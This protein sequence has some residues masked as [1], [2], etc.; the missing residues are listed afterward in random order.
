MAT[1]RC[2]TL[3]FTPFAAA[4]CLAQP[5]RPK[6]IKGTV[7]ECAL[8]AGLGVEFVKDLPAAGELVKRLMDGSVA[9]PKKTK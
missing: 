6:R 7:A 1:R 5:H 9:A 3:V 4:L 8:F 2:F